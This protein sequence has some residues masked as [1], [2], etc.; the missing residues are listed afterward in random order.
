[1]SFV[2]TTFL[3]SLIYAVLAFSGCGE[4][5][6]P[7]AP[8]TPEAPDP[9]AGMTLGDLEVDVAAGVPPAVES[10]AVMDNLSDEFA[11]EGKGA[12]F[13]ENWNDSYHNG[14]RGPGLT[15]FSSNHSEVMNGELVLRAARVPNSNRVFCGVV[16]GKDLLEFPAYT[17]VSAKVA[18]QVLSSNFWFLSDD[19]RREVDVVEIY[20]SS[21]EDHNWFAARPSTNYHVFIRDENTN[22]ILENFNN[23]QHHPKPDLEPYRNDFHRYG[24]Y[25]KDAFTIDFYYDGELVHQ[26]RRAGITDPENLGIDRA[27]NMIFDLEDH[28]W[29]SNA[30]NVATDDELTDEPDRTYRIDYVRTYRPRAAFDGGLVENGSF[31]LPGLDKWYHLGNVSLSADPAANGGEAV[32][33][34]LGSGAR[35]TQRIAVSPNTNYTLNLRLNA[36]AGIRVAVV[37][38]E[39]VSA[40]A[41]AWATETVTFN[42]GEKTEVFLELRN[43]GSEEALIDAVEL[44]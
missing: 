23:Q 37:D 7:V 13:D 9:T 33:L 16:T 20:G 44:R 41:D 28:D 12:E 26:L 17:E 3:Y 42:S 6:M 15:Q 31:D 36:P 25:W 38:V 10:W 2:R 22:A 27:M 14:W 35:V 19:D 8:V 32:A 39:T 40:R 29:R 21:R 18:D 24:M 43:T 5:E 34:R 4:D 11:Y 1:M 30:G